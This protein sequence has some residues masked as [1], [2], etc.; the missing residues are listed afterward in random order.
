MCH[1]MPG[2]I[3]VYICTNVTM[4]ILV[5]VVVKHAGVPPAS[6]QPPFGPKGKLVLLPGAFGRS[7]KV[8]LA[9]AG[10]P[11]SCG[12]QGRGCNRPGT[13]QITSDIRC[14]CRLCAPFL[15]VG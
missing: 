8:L 9:G 2:P 6:A 11:K 4:N 7:P 12:G 1:H 10:P 15:T 13:A 14:F 5:L 3:L